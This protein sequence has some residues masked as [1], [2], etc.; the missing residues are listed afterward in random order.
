MSDEEET[1]EIIRINNIDHYKCL[2]C[3]FYS[4]HKNSVLRHQSKKNS[5]Y[6]KKE[7]K[8]EFCN[9]TFANSY[10]LNSHLSRKNKCKKDDNVSEEDN[11][12]D[13]IQ[14]EN[15][16]LKKEL[17]NQKE[18][19]KKLET[20][21]LQLKHLYADNHK[22]NLETL[23]FISNHYAELLLEKDKSKYKYNLEFNI[24]RTSLFIYPKKDSKSIK[25]QLYLLMDIIEMDDVEKIF[26]KIK[27]EKEEYIPF[28][29]GYYKDLKQS[30]KQKV[31][32]KTTLTYIKFLERKIEEYF[33]IH[34]S[35]SI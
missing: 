6:I 1:Y 11:H 22:T 16:L 29:I 13:D 20:T 2:L 28:I 7:Y 14:S 3:S 19:T 8:C 32:N 35:S 21:L 24:L 17:E 12:T 5:C 25:E 33:G 34:V 10:N 31:Y 27:I 26:D 4:R 15:E 30:D 23:I 18:I 9:C